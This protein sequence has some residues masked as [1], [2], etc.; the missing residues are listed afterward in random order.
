MQ[1][2]VLAFLSALVVVP[3][4]QA[5]GACRACD[6]TGRIDC[7]AHRA[8]DLALEREGVL[9]RLYAGCQSCGGTMRVDCSH[10]DTTPAQP[11]EEEGA[12]LKALHECFERYDAIIGRPL[13]GAASRH[14]NLVCE[15]MPMR[16]EGRRRSQHELLHLYLERLEAVHAAYLATFGLSEEALTARSEVFLWAQRA[17]HERIG[18]ELCGYTTDDPMFRRGLEAISSLWPDPRKLPDDEALHHGAVHLVVHGMMNVQE[19]VAYTGNLRMGWA[20]EGLSL[21]FEDRLFDRISGFCF[22]TEDYQGLFAPGKWRAALRK[23]L[24]ADQPFDLM[25]LLE[26]DSVTLTR[27]DQALGFSLIDHLAARDL[28]RLTKLLARLRAHTPARD[29]LMEV[30]GLSLEQVEKDWR[31][32]VAKTYPK[33]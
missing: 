14:F 28:T 31:A 32:W 21:W 4:R 7:G 33:R 5:G 8:A 29:A 24:A 16:A 10:C 22:W 9:C 20:D 23:R 18:K 2:W 26:L 6:G 17:D 15:L 3:S 13:L 30:Y 25:A 11:S 19:P 12:R 27:E 1:L